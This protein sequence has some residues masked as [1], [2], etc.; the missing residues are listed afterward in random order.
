MKTLFAL[1][2]SAP[3]PASALLLPGADAGELLR[4]CAL[5]SS[6]RLRKT[7]LT[8]P[9][10]LPPRG[11]G[12]Q[13]VPAP[14]SL[15]GRGVGGEGNVLAPLSLLGRG[16]WGWRGDFFPQPPE[17]AEPL[18]I[19]AT[20]IHAVAG[21]F[22]E[23]RL[24]VSPDGPGEARDLSRRHSPARAAVGE[25]VRAGRCQARRRL[26]WRMRQ[27]P[28]CG[29]RGLVFLP[30]GTVLEFSP[31]VLLTAAELIA[32]P[33]LPSP[34]GGRCR[35][36]PE[37]PEQ[38]HEI[39]LDIPDPPPDA[40]IESGGSGIGVEMPRPPEAGPGRTLAGNA[41]AM[42]EQGLVWLGDK[43]GW[44]GLAGLG[45]SLVARAIQAVPRISESVMG[46]Q[47]AALREMLRQFREGN[48]EDALRRAPCRSG[49]RGG[50]GSSAAQNANL[51]THSLFY[52]LGEL[53]EAGQGPGGVW[54]AASNVYEDLEA[55]YR[56]AA[57]EATR[58]GDFR[59]AAFIYGKLLQDWRLA[60][61]VLGRGG[62]HHDS[63]ILYLEKLHDP[64]AAAK[65]F[66][67]GGEIDRALHL[68]RQRGEHTLAGDL[69]MRSG[70]DGTRRS[71]EF[72]PGGRPGSCSS[73]RYLAAGELLLT[74]AHRS[75]LAEA[76]LRDRLGAPPRRE[77]PGLPAAPGR[78]VCQPADTGA[79]A[80][81]AGRDGRVFRRSRQRSARGRFLQPADAA[82]RE[83][84]SRTDSRRSARSRLAGTGAQAPAAGRRRQGRCGVADVR[85]RR[86]MG[87]VPGA[88][89]SRRGARPAAQQTGQKRDDAIE[90]ARRTDHSGLRGPGD[91]RSIPWDA[92]MA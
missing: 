3:E 24:P 92:R 13:E 25:P 90:D 2:K 34:H 53:L 1:R 14:L 30:G 18:R 11:E 48:I 63:A 80:E 88:R 87:A 19:T 23:Y 57:E 65:E 89:C 15:L 47:E 59:R 70:E 66:E 29:S 76:L 36:R 74:H 27:T 8:P 83:R 58:R 69:L 61:G 39:L 16:G 10:P 50:R 81:T 62:L 21:G 85:Q 26:C 67:A 35:P 45:A 12:E 7:P 22:P 33:R 72:H 31:S 4:L 6:E 78:T 38:L 41:E 73:G 20:V 54:F 64:L 5:C 32:M 55:A 52:R 60:A 9:P 68:Y 71:Q 56:R 79:A 46:Q 77:R 42:L 49:Q 51:P 43:L 28:S 84:P 17:N 91:R 86:R 44:K 37:R 40:I 75:D 82:G